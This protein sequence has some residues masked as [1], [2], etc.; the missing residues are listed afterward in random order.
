MIKEIKDANDKDKDQ[1]ATMR[2]KQRDL[3]NGYSKNKN[4]SLLN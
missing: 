1:Q 2:N 4:V 3:K